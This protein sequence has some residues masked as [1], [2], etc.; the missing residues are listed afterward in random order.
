MQ[1]V[2]AVTA[3]REIFPVGTELHTHDDFRLVVLPVFPTAH[4]TGHIVRINIKL[5]QQAQRPVFLKFPARQPIGDGIGRRAR[6]DRLVP[7]AVGPRVEGRPK[8]IITVFVHV[9]HKQERNER[10]HGRTAQI[11]ERHIGQ[12]VI[13]HHVI[14]VVRVDNDCRLRR[15]VAA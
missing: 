12:T 7:Q 2:T 9:T 8:K 4:F 15:V 3:R 5:V 1:E 11:I 6:H 13:G 14:C 10:G